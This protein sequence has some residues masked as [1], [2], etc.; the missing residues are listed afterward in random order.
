[1]AK[2]LFDI[3]A[4]LLGLAVMT[5]LLL[6]VAVAVKMSSRGPVLFRQV[7]VGRGGREF[8]LLKFR[9][10][11]ADAP[12]LGGQL[13]VEGD[14][15]ITPVGRA[16]RASKLDE[17]PQLWNVVVGDMSLVGPRPEVPKYVALYNDEQ[18]QVLSVRPG[19]T[20]YASIT[21]FDENALLARSADP[22]GTYVREIMPHKLRLNHLYLQRRSFFEDIRILLATAFVAAVRAAGRAGRVMQV[23]SDALVVV[24]AFSGAYLLRFDFPIPDLYG[25]QLILLLPYTVLARLAMNLVFG[26]YRVMWR[27]VSLYEV[28][29]FAKAIASVTVVFLAFRLVP[30]ENPYYR[31]PIS[32]IVIEG[33]LSFLGMTG[34]RF[35]RRWLY[36]ATS[37]A[38]TGAGDSEKAIVV[39]AGDN[40]RAI[41]HEIR[42]RPA[43]GLS[44]VGF[45]DDDPEKQGSEI[46]GSKVLGTLDVLKE[47]HARTGF[48]KVLLS[49]AD[50]PLQR[51][52][53]VMELCAGRGVRVL[54]LPGASQLISG[55]AQVAAV[56]DVAIEDLLGRE[57]QELAED[58]PLL[59]PVYGGRRVLVTGAGGSIGSELC[60]QISAL[61]PALLI[62]LDKDENNLF[63]IRGEMAWMRP[64]LKT[65]A[66]VLDVRARDKLQRVFAEHRPEV[67]LHAAA[68][69]HVPLMEENPFEAVENNIAGTRNVAE[70]AQIHGSQTFVMLSTDKA[71]NPTSV[72]GASKR[73]AELIVRGLAA[74]GGGTR[75]ASVRFGNVLGSRGSVIPLFRDQI[76]RG[77]PV[78]VT[79][80]DVVRYFMTI[81]EASQLVLKAGTIGRDG[82]V[83]VLDMGAPIRI[84]DLA[85]DMIR[86]S[87]F[88]DGEIPI[89]YTGLRPGEKL[90]EE[91]LLDRDRVLP[92]QVD[93]VF[94]S[95][96]ELRDFDAW[97]GKVDALVAEARV[98]DRAAIRALMEAMDIGLRAAD[99]GGAEPG[100]GG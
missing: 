6:L 3:V 5:P 85:R 82:E 81:P 21:Y 14:P 35:L 70:L 25:K 97:M 62:L 40:G 56:R 47:L 65:V 19:I 18:R 57:V 10:M 54:V 27:Y 89:A 83:F 77:G 80:P 78:T 38:P 29:R 76:A 94:V 26:V 23:V 36:E 95:R 4:S 68:Y 91:L 30:T 20:D 59:G 73:I 12:R 100:R 2:R 33:V 86:L 43:L 69:K 88:H 92:T 48:T 22:E 31:I 45:V 64:A 60:R 55:Q 7:R 53:E 66:V 41:A 93:K 50:L 34:M 87:G 49:I 51:K 52:R 8:R 37:A 90:F 28:G 1:M 72:M 32:I 13:T 61:D 39:G 96:P 16:L 98:A 67:V 63:H 9:T 46:E 75:F 99:V 15:R 58:D 84:V 11:V 24:V 74:K 71:V 79:H 42:L 17:F 44:L